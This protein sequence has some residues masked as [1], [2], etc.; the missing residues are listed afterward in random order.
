MRSE[1]LIPDL[2]GPPPTELAHRPKP[3]LGWERSD[4]QELGGSVPHWRSLRARETLIE[5][6]F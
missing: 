6:S 3:S 2:G 5:M 1:R 4:G